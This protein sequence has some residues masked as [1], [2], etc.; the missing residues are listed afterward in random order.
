MIYG[1]L[2]NICGSTFIS[3]G[4]NSIHLSYN[5]KNQRIR[6]FGYFLFIAGNVSNFIS[7]SYAT[8][9]ILSSVSCATLILGNNL[10][11][12]FV[13]KVKITVN[14]VISS[15][16]LLC[17]VILIISFSNN[18][19]SVYSVNEMMKLYSEFWYFIFLLTE[20][21]LILVFSWVYLKYKNSYSYVI[22]CCMIGTHSIVFS[23][24]LS[25]ILKLTIEG[26]NQF[27]Y[28]FTYFII[29]L[30]IFTSIFW[31]VQLNK[32]LRKYNDN[33]YI[34]PVQQSLWMLF[35][36]VSSGIYFKE[37]EMFS[38]IETI[39]FLIGISL[40]ITGIVIIKPVEKELEIDMYIRSCF[41]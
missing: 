21:F 25:E 11:N 26:D 38:L 23:K 2:L 27:C 6:I 28:F 14:S 37:F 33:H 3:F 1:V 30:L 8:Q 24:S 13:K 10:F 22:V 36:I 5:K 18:Q 39:I 34:V 12:F 32:I 15:G 20:A 7:F 9:I 17:G 35:S 31:I 4:T 41:I 19:T 40:I 16:L 29:A